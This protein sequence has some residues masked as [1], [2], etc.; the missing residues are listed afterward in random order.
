M[1]DNY[2]GYYTTL[3]IEKTQDRTAIWDGFCSKYKGTY[4]LQCPDRLSEAY[5]V[6]STPELKEIYDNYGEE[7][8]KSGLPNNDKHSGY[9][10]KG[11]DF[12]DLYVKMH[13]LEPENESKSAKNENHLY[14]DLT[15]TLRELYN[16]CI[17]T[18]SYKRDKLPHYSS[19]KVEN[20]HFEKE[21]EIKPG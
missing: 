10:Y 15:C 8:L 18:I 16:G 21:I 20:L 1:D 11:N 7:V 17:K 3:G 4:P 13:G 19:R 14:V 6:L 2:T 12:K 9:C 5:E